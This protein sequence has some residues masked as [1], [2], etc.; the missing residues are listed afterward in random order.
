LKICKKRNNQS[1]LTSCHLTSFFKK[2]IFQQS[3]LKEETLKTNLG[4]PKHETFFRSEYSICTVGS[5]YHFLV[6]LITVYFVPTFRRK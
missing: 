4:F 5:F 3:T 1:K 2:E 6:S